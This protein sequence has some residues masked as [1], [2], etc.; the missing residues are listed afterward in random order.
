MGVSKPCFLILCFFFKLPKSA[1]EYKIT[2][3]Q[4]YWKCT[5]SCFISNLFFCPFFTWIK[6]EIIKL[7]QFIKWENLLHMIRITKINSEIGQF[8]MG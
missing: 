3:A 7:K 4:E 2:E 8:L 6:K 1:C 5:E